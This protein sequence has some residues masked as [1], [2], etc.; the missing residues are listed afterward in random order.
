VL[1]RDLSAH[2]F[3]RAA[4]GGVAV[5]EYT[6]ANSEKELGYLQCGLAIGRPV[7]I[8]VVRAEFEANRVRNGS[9]G[10]TLDPAW[11]F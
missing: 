6:M 9:A 4:A 5:R 8:C 3:G 7:L 11:R 2:V 1:K 10:T